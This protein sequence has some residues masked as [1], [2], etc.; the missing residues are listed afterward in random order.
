MHL[1]LLNQYCVPDMAPTGQV[2]FDLARSLV[3]RGHRVTVLCSRRSYDGDCSYPAREVRDGVA[4]ERLPAFGFGRR[5]FLGKLLDYASFYVLLAIRLLFL[6][7]RPSLILALTTPPYVGLLAKAV[8]WVRRIPHAHWVMDLYPD[9]MVAHGMLGPQSLLRRVLARLTRWELRGSAATLALGPDMAERL[10]AYSQ[11]TVPWVP[12]WG[13]G[14]LQP[15]PAGKPNRLREARGWDAE[16]LVLMYSGNMGLGH[17]F[18][19]FLA[20]AREL[21]DD[22]TVRWVFAG[23]GKRRG[24]VEA[25]VAADSSLPIALLPY[26]P[27]GELA[28]HLASADVLLASL[29]PAWQGCMVP[30]KLQGVFAVGRPVIF[31]GAPDNSL[32]TWIT[33]AGAGWVVPPDDLPALAAAVAAARNPAERHRRGQAAREYATTHFDQQVNC[34]RIADLLQNSVPPAPRTP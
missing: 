4:I 26:A 24:E 10:A 17:R 7:P 5:S 32:A 31:V 28:E 8:G 1:V 29:E 27:L 22:P 9:V 18:G 20:C 12:L 14:A 11:T 2:L 25:A 23:G 16:T 6:R 13:D 15:W 34:L 21:R 30:S 3:A 33:A 19:E